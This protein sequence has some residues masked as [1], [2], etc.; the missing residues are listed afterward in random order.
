MN[1]YLKNQEDLL[2]ERKRHTTHRVASARSGVQ[3]IGG[4]GMQ[5]V[6]PQEGT[7]VQ[8]WPGGREG[9][10][11]PILP[12]NTSEWGTLPNLG[13]GYL[14]WDW[15]TPEM[16]WDQWKYYGM[17]MWYPLP[18]TDRYLRKC[19]T[20]AKSPICAIKYCKMHEKASET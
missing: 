8:S 19:F 6:L 15:D 7:T 1:E 14:P 9:Y 17:E 18:R 10:P 20:M 12:E 16:T 5:S 3:S 13:L 2:R 4:G 11:S